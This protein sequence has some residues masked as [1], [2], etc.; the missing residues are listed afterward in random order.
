M[1]THALKA[2]STRRSS[3]AKKGKAAARTPARDPLE[4]L[5]RICTQHRDNPFVRFL[6]AAFF[7][8]DEALSPS[9]RLANGTSRAGA[10]SVARGSLQGPFAAA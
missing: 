9:A 10:R 5:G 1:K 3:S 8:D 2:L 4:S 7:Y 6:R